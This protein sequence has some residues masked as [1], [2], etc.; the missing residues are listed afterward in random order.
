ML[1]EFEPIE[2]LPRSIESKRLLLRQVQ[3]RDAR[4]IAELHT[5]AYAKHL[6]PWSPQPMPHEN[7]VEAIADFESFTLLALERWED[8]LDYRFAIVLKDTPSN[9][10]SRGEGERKEVDSSTSRGEGERKEVDSSTS[11]GEGERKEVDSYPSLVQRE[12]KDP[13]IGLIGITNIIRGVSRAGFIG[14]WIGADHINQ[15]YATEATVLAMQYAFEMLGLHRINLW[16]ATDNAPSLR[17]AEKLGLRYEG[18]IIKAL[19]LGGQWKDTKSFA[20]LIDEWQER[21]E[22]L[23]QYASV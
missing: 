1:E 10:P 14:Y 7:L 21:R 18:T 15:G 22:D 5:D 3:L 9:S 13:I 2:S 17:I 19:Y 11:R 16:I 6:R 23:L 4:E 12:R 20:I 8:D